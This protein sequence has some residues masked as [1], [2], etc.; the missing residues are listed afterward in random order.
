MDG[1]AGV[2]GP[3]VGRDVLHPVDDGV[4]VAGCA[5]VFRS[6]CDA[7]EYVAFRSLGA[8]TL[9]VHPGLSAGQL[10]IGVGQQGDFPAAV[11]YLPRLGDNPGFQEILRLFGQYIDEGS[12]F[13]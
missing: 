6:A 1:F 8:L 7:Y 13:E 4:T 3:D 5:R 12:G 9:I 10:S 11:I 2:V